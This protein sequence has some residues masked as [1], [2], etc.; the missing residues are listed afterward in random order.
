MNASEI[1]AAHV[2]CAAL[3][4]ELLEGIAEVDEGIVKLNGI[5]TEEVARLFEPEIYH[6][7]QA[8]GVEFIMVSYYSFKFTYIR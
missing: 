4:V 3:N 1:A 5:S 8:L 7:T 2:L 6:T